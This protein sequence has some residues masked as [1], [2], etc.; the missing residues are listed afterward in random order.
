MLL[1]SSLRQWSGIADDLRKKLR[2]VNFPLANHAQS[3]ILQI[4]VTFPRKGDL[5]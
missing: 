4:V 5:G 2:K 3:S 1:E